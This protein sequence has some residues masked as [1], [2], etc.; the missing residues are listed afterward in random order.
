[1]DQTG[2][3]LD[4]LMARDYATRLNVEEVK[5]ATGLTYLLTEMDKYFKKDS[6][7]SIFLAI[8][9]LENFRR[10]ELSVLEYISE[11][12]RRVSQ[13]SETMGKADSAPLYDDCF[14]A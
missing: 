9:E 5:K 1:M 6:T 11:F 13:L 8:D 2:C 14:L 10:G 4:D 7:Q 3:G 12:T